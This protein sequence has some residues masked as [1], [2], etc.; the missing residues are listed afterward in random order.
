LYASLKAPLDRSL[1]RVYEESIAKDGQEGSDLH[2]KMD[3]LLG[4]GKSLV[5]ALLLVC[6]LAACNLSNTG[7][8]RVTT[9]TALPGPVSEATAIP[10]T[11]TRLSVGIILTPLS[12]GTI[13]R[14]QGAGYH[15][16]NL[17]RP[18][19]MA[20]VFVGSDRLDAHASAGD[21]YEVVTTLSS[22]DQVEVI[23]GPQQSG[24]KSWW[25]IRFQGIE[26][27]VAG[28]GEKEYQT[29]VPVGDFRFCT[30]LPLIVGGAAE[31]FSLD[32]A[33]SLFSA[34]TTSAPIVTEMPVN[35]RVNIT[36]GAQTV[37]QNI[38]YGVRYLD[39]TGRTWDGFAVGRSGNFCTLHPVS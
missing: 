26:G 20:V 13:S 7:R 21:Q 11:P 9:P 34:A 5:I 38:W 18:G 19:T 36:S 27:W 10:A 8:P 2:W 37:G 1:M 28:L 12:P 14:G 32:G 6:S 3:S 4:N 35:S 39:D 22:F 17:P 23:E 15:G 16:I 30:D 25:K 33:L 24:V 29:L 31:V